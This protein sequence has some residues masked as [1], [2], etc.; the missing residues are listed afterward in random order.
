MSTETTPAPATETKGAPK[1][2]ALAATER[3]EAATSTWRANGW[4]P[5]WPPSRAS[6]PMS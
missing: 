1:G 6:T 4:A 2:K 5:S 3:I